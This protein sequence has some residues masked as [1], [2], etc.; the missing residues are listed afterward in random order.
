[1]DLQKEIAPRF[2]KAIRKFIPAS[3][4]VLVSPY[5][6]LGVRVIVQMLGATKKAPPRV[7]ATVQAKK[8]GKPQECV[9]GLIGGAVYQIRKATGNL[10]I[11]K[12]DLPK[13]RLTNRQ[14]AAERLKR[15]IAATEY[16]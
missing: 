10:G 2:E 13:K 4:E 7:L 16:L 15:E 11:P 6:V 5:D 14:R 1:M 3:A 8:I 9:H 12:A